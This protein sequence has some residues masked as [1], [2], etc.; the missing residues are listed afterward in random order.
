M[1]ADSGRQWNWRSFGRRVL[2]PLTAMWDS[3]EPLNAY[4]LTH[5]ASAAGDALVAIALADS[6][7]FSLPVDRAKVRIALYLGLT[8]APLAIAAPALVP[9]L[10]RTGYRRLISFGASAGRAV[11]AIY[12]APR[13]ST[14]VLFPVA[15]ALLALSRVHAVTKTSLTMA[16]ATKDG[17]V[18]ANA[19]LGRMSATGVAIA[20]APGL[21]LLNFGGARSVLYLAAASFTV[22]SLLNLRLA[23]PAASTTRGDAA[24]GGRLPSLAVAAAGTAGLRAAS[25]FLLFLMAFSLRG[26][27]HPPYWFGV[28]AGFAT[29]GALVGDLAAS[30]IPED[31]HEEFLVRASLA[32]AGVAALVASATFTLPV[33]AVFAG[34]AGGALEIGRLAF[35]SLMQRHVPSGA[36]GRVFVRY[37]VAFQLAWVAGA[38]IPAVLPI[39]FR[40]GVLL[41]ALFYLGLA[42]GRAIGPAVSKWARGKRPGG[43]S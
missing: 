2:R 1:R 17:L 31:V 39:P 42:F 37:E 38:F 43:R 12:A 3:D 18:Q 19:K 41:M 27:G 6:I 14:L 5:M 9:L 22:A 28:L 15:F 36:Q 25:G 24:R 13:F 4:A 40:L 8:M 29:V 23:Q 30:R 16:Y 10:D 32:G 33:L 34:L 35:Q 21:V 20:A 7:F 11:A 26:R